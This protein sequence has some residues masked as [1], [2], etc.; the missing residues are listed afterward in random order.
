MYVLFDKTYFLFPPFIFVF[1]HLCQ[2]P[3]KIVNSK[4]FHLLSLSILVALP[5]QSILWHI[6]SE[7]YIFG[8]TPFP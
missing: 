8:H 4:N 5:S 3:V 6:I 1:C 2:L 7:M